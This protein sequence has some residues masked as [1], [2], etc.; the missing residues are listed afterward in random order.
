MLN[1]LETI[2]HSSLI[3]KTDLKGSGY[4]SEYRTDDSRLTIEIINTARMNHAICCNY[5]EAKSFILEQN[6]MKGIKAF[7]HDSGK[8]IIINATKIINASG[9]WSDDV[10]LFE[11]EDKNKNLILSKGTHIVLPISKIP[12]R[13][14]MYFDVA[15][16]RMIFAIKRHDVVDIGT[17]DT[18][19][20]R[21]IESVSASLEDVNYLIKA[22]NEM[23]PDTGISKNDIISSWSGLRP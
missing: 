20:D 21:D 23:F 3:K 22:C 1:K 18:F 8:E 5:I 11:D 15:D 10:R 16:G 19:Y 9:P 7:D 17:T 12:I 14:S 4:Y 13:N 2:E 6:E